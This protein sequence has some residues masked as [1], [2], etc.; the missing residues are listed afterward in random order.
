M[1]YKTPK[2]AAT[3]K[4]QTYWWSFRHCDRRREISFVHSAALVD[5]DGNI[6]CRANI[7]YCNRTWERYSGD[8]VRASLAE[9][10]ERK[11]TFNSPAEFAEV[12][13][14]IEQLKISQPVSSVSCDPGTRVGFS[15]SMCCPM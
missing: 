13:P 14:L 8:S 12:K 5:P 1:A 15:L 3:G 4:Y 7:G 11:C 10:I 2:F 6:V 9:K